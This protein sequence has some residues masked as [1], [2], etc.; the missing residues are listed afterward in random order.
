MSVVAFIRRCISAGMDMATALTAA[1][2]F[3]ESAPVYVPAQSK[4]AQRTRKWRERKAEQASQTVTVTLGDDGDARDA[5]ASPPLVRT[6]V[7]TPTSSLRSEGTQEAN[8]SFVD[9]STPAE[10]KKPPTKPPKSQRGTRLPD[11]W[12]P[13][14]EE[15]DL[16]RIAGL[17][18]EEIHRA[19][20][21][22]RN[23]WC[24]RSRD[25]TKLSWRLTWHNRVNELGDRKRRASSR[26]AAA[27]AKPGGGRRGASSFADIYARRHGPAEDGDA[28]S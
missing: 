28:L 9:A 13:S 3:E 4:G 26:L 7:V 20:L 19:A 2:A 22:F 14:A 24:S 18:D 16:G 21:E 8:A 25:A 11:D 1:E 23:Y 6:Q 27:P 15:F 17:T 10:P 5:K 12:E